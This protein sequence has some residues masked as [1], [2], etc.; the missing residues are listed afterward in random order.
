MLRN[1]KKTYKKI[2]AK[3][4]IWLF[5]VIPCANTLAAKTLSKSEYQNLFMASF[6]YMTSIKACNLT[7]MYAL[8]DETV[9]RAI[10]YGYKYSLHDIHTERISQNV[11]YYTEQGIAAYQQTAKVSCADA[12]GYMRTIANAVQQLN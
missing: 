3:A 2:T 5:L 9:N 12:A 10:K 1:H 6:T 8:A 11:R 4:L 7:S